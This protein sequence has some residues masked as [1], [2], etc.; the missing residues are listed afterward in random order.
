MTY[1]VFGGTLNLAQPTAQPTQSTQNRSFRRRSS[2]P[3]SWL[4]L[5]GG[6]GR[7]TNVYVIALV[8]EV[9]VDGL[10]QTS[11]V[12]AAAGDCS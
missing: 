3:I 9:A 4:V 11:G 6:P 8:S 12:T 7:S 10:M 2:Q 1:N 5:S